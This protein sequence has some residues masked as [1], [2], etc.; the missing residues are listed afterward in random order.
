MRESSFDLHSV[1]LL[2]GIY[3][4]SNSMGLEKELSDLWK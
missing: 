1:L 2:A 3:I 4:D